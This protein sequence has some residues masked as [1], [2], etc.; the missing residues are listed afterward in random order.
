MSERHPGGPD[1]LAG[2]DDVD[3]ASHR[4]AYG[5]AADVPGLLRA[6]YRP[7]EAADAADTL[8]MSVHHQGG[9]VASAA[10]A[11]LPFLVRAATDPSVDAPV[12][13]DLVDLVACVA[14]EGNRVEPRWIAPGWAEAWDTAVPGLLPL[15]HDPEPEVR[16]AAVGALE[17]AHGRADE[18]LA[19]LWTR[20]ARET[21]PEVLGALVDAAGELAGHAD[22]ERE[23]TLA[24]LRGLTAPDAGPGERLRAVAALRV[25]GAPGHHARVVDEVLAGGDLGGYRVAEAVKLLGG[26]LA[27]RTGHLTRLLGHPTASTRREALEAAAGELSRRRSAVPLLLPT[28][29]ELLDDPEPDNRLFAARVLGMCGTAALPWAD[30]LAAMTDDEGE[31]Y[32]P[33]QDHALWALSRTGDPRCA[34][35]LARRLGGER[36]GFGYFSVHSEGWWTHELSLS[37]TLGPLAAHARV[38]LPPLRT[39]LAAVRSVDEARALAQVLTAWGPAAAPAVPELCG[40]LETDGAV[41]A[42]EALAAI[43]PEAAAAVDRDRLRALIDAPPEGLPFAARALARAYGRLTGDRGPAL[44]LYL[45]RLDEPYGND[46]TAIVLGELGPAGAPYADRLR[47][48]LRSEATGWVPVRVGEA[49]WRITGRAEEVVPVLVAAVE[50]YTGGGATRAVTETVRLLGR[51]GPAAAPAVPVL[52]AFLDADERPV[53]H[54]GWRSVPEDDE[55]CAAARAALRATAGPAPRG[56]GTPPD[57][58]D[59]RM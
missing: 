16:T 1:P 59:R 18:A 44:A 38:L 55:L 58:G 4:H 39:R 50:P 20:H 37:E 33:A 5:P 3:W 15:L 49:L 42:A 47:E 17:E 7:D 43:G 51:I 6:L 13:I 27:E 32:L 52:R 11:A 23:P 24:R 36:L 14:A 10:V 30:R 41:W 53:E 48:L 29:A 34:A 9:C 19:A 12:R 8:Y 25:A 2:L 46:H 45:P 22:R 21:V 40:L 57:Q 28:A 54:G 31:P 26:T 35:P 56:A